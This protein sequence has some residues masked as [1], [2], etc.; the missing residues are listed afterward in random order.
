MSTVVKT[1]IV[2]MGNSQGVR[3]PKPVLEQVGLSGPVEIEVQTDQLILRAAALPPRHGWDEAFQRM[4]ANGDDA[5]LDAE[6]LTAS[7]W[8]NEEW[9]W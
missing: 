8:D 6:A 2:K 3:I 9:Q 7:E 5:L 4:A 1:K